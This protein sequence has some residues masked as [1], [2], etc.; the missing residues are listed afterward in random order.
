MEEEEYPGSKSD[1]TV[2]N[3]SATGRVSRTDIH[4]KTT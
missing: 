2:Y 4:V 1:N 3:A